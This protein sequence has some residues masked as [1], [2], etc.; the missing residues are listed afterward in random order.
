VMRGRE[1]AGV[2]FDGREGSG[3]LARNHGTEELAT[4]GVEVSGVAA[5]DAGIG[6]IVVEGVGLVFRHGIESRVG[7][8]VEIEHHGVAL[9]SD[10]AHGGGIILKRADVLAVFVLAL[11]QRGD[12]DGDSAGGTRIAN[13]ITHVFGES[14][15]RD[16]FQQRPFAGAVVGAELDENVVGMNG[17]GTVPEALLAV[18]L[19]A[20]AVTR[21]VEALG[22]GGLAFAKGC[23]QPVAWL[24]VESP[25][26]TIRIT[27]GSG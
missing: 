25:A 27:W 16:I 9:L 20:A 26:R 12:E 17:E 15:G 2:D 22:I 1:S 13:I 21:A 3:E 18:A 8:G 4:L 6:W 7:L 19:C 14:G 11:R 23:T 5:R 24:T 10:G